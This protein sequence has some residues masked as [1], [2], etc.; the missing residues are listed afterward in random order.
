MPYFRVPRDPIRIGVGSVGGVSA[1]QQACASGPS[2]DKALEKSCK[3]SRARRES[4]SAIASQMKIHLDYRIDQSAHDDFSVAARC[5][6]EGRNNSYAPSRSE[7][8][9]N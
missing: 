3:F 1:L 8:R 2:G 7:Y 4:L 9:A 6:S 5:Y